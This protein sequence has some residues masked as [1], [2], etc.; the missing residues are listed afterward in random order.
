MNAVVEKFV[1]H[2]DSAQQIL[3]WLKAGRGVAHWTS[4]DLSDPGFALTTPALTSDAVPTPKPH[5][6]LGN[7][8]ERII[9]DAA[10]IEV[11]EYE[12]ATRFHVGIRL[13]GNGLAWKCTDGA[14]RR[15][16]RALAKYGP[17]A[18]YTFDYLNQD[19]LIFKPTGSKPLTDWTGQ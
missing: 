5:W 16:R 4:I 3:G 17:D 8:P 2:A 12:L 10:E 7:Q 13:G 19:C 14:S 6:K 9:F 18:T 15:I 11:R 1:I